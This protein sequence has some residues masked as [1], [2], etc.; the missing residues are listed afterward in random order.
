MAIWPYHARLF[1]QFSTA[2][3]GLL[4][5]LQMRVQQHGMTGGRRWCWGSHHFSL[6][7]MSGGVQCALFF[8]QE[9]AIWRSY[10][11]NGN[12]IW[13]YM[14]PLYDIIYIC[15][16]NNLCH[17][18]I[19]TYIHTY[20]LPLSLYAIVYV[21]MDC[22]YGRYIIII[23]RMVHLCSRKKHVLPTPQ[24]IIADQTLYLQLQ[25]WETSNIVLD[26]PNA[27]TPKF[28]CQ[29]LII[30]DHFEHVNQACRT[31]RWE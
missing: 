22:V 20:M 3:T 29:M 7:P 12:M 13:Y 30:F 11:T 31:A 26:G 4:I 9:R 28:T 14:V 18:C 23:Y 19:Y 6:V 21:Y 10:D 25:K 8:G 5:D 2:P 24:T 16:S 1:F 27:Y 17:I 15:I